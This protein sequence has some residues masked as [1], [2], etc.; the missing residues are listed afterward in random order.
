[1]D[2]HDDI[3]ENIKYG[4]IDM[5]ILALLTIEDMY[6]YRIKTELAQSDIIPIE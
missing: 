2:R 5:L 1:M 6:G 3:E 4:L